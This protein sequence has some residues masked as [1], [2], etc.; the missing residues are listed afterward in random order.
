MRS[1]SKPHGASRWSDA[2]CFGTELQK[3]SLPLASPP[4]RTTTSSQGHRRF[5]AKQKT[6]AHAGMVEFAPEGQP[7]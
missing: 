6:R 1:D 4:L 7:R 5:P 3:H 2:F